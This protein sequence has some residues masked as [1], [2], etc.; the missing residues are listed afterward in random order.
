MDENSLLTSQLRLTQQVVQE[1]IEIVCWLMQF[2]GSRRLGRY[3]LLFRNGVI[4]RYTFTNS[5]FYFPYRV[6]PQC[7]DGPDPEIHYHSDFFSAHQRKKDS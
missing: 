2:I 5:T 3:Y 7:A 4:A 6:E 1:L